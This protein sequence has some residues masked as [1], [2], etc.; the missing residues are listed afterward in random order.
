MKKIDIPF[1][2]DRIYGLTIPENS[3]MHIVSHDEV[4]RLDLKNPLNVDVLVDNPYEFANTNHCLG[5]PDGKPIHTIEGKKVEFD[6]DP[7]KETVTIAVH[8]FGH[9]EEIKFP[10]MSGDWFQASFSPCGQYFVVAEPYAYD[11]YEFE[12]A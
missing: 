12:P 5:I 9:I 11:V 8:H 6:F 1:I 3:I 7:T 10:L 2:C 4:S